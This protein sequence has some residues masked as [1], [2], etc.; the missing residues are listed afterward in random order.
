MNSLQ[1]ISTFLDFQ[2]NL[3]KVPSSFKS[4]FDQAAIENVLS[5]LLI[6]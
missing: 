3:P 4:L 6:C 1:K 2:R 5:K